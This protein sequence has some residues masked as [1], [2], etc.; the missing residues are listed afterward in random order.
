MP[1]T[2]QIDD[3]AH[4][5]WLRPGAFCEVSVPIGNARQAI[6]ILS[7]A[8]QPTATGSLVYTVDD[9]S[10]AH[11]HVVQL[12]MYTPDGGVEITQGLTVGDLFVV[13]GF[14][15]LSEGA[16]GEDQ[17]LDHAAGGAEQGGGPRRG[18]HAAAVGL[19][20][21]FSSGA[22]S[23]SMAS[24]RAATSAKPGGPTP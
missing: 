13:E 7:I 17:R 4:K 9:K 10:I 18:G 21:S 22:A 19:G 20:R 6:V 24:A 11:Q 15:A 14:E 1:V 12:G 3:T 23:P 8:V 2:G 16:P 5:Y